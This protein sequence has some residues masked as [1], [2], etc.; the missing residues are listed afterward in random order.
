MLCL[1]RQ[2][3]QMLMLFDIRNISALLGLYFQLNVTVQ[4]NQIS[5][6][7][8]DIDSNFELNEL[9]CKT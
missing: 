9:S 2:A 4:G 5:V 1:L 8:T 7:T 6:Q 3:P